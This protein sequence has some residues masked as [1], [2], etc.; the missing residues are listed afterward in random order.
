M[1]IVLDADG[2]LVDYNEQMA[3]IAGKIL[4]K[5]LNK[6]AHAHH[7][8]NAYDVSFTKE[9]KNMVYKLFETE[10]WSAMPPVPGAVE[11]TQQLKSLGHTLVCLSSMPNRFVPD[12]LHNLQSHGMPIDKVIGSGRDNKSPHINPKAEHL[13]ALNPQIFVDDQLR[14]FQDIPDTICRVWINN[15][16]QDCPNQGVDRGLADF[17]FSSL[18]D[19]AQALAA[20]PQA[21]STF[22]RQ[23]T[24]PKTAGTGLSF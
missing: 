2:V 14:N 18:Q 6:V 4:K 15:N 23:P 17:T 20:N 13:R 7:F 16:F 8:K 10:G 12:R 11:G 24:L 19:F 22:K 1:L 9:E 5:T 21:F 3:K